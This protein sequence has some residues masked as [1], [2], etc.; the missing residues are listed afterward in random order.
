MEKETYLDFQIGDDVLYF[1][2]PCT[3]VDIDKR[4]HGHWDFHI[5]NM[6]NLTMWAEGNYLEKPNETISPEPLL[7]Q[8]LIKR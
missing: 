6:Q 4:Q 5:K 7:T 8:T 3:I 2:E 1:D